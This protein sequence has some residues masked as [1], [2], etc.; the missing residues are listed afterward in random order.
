MLEG[1]NHVAAHFSTHTIDMIDLMF[2]NSGG[3]MATLMLA[4]SPQALADRITEQITSKSFL[5]MG[6]YFRKLKGTHAKIRAAKHLHAAIERHKIKK[7]LANK[8][9]T[10]LRGFAD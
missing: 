2:L 9:K 6:M 10:R 7:G 5:Q 4:Y 3:E 8:T 1:Y